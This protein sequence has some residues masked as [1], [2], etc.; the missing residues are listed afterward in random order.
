VRSSCTGQSLDSEFSNGSAVGQ[1]SGAIG[2][3]D[4]FGI[5]SIA[6]RRRTRHRGGN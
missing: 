2:K 3:V 4:E 5:T 6:L 1:I